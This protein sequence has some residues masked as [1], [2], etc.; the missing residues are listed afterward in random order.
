MLTN[1][2]KVEILNKLEDSAWEVLTS[3][4][5]STSYEY[6]VLMNIKLCREVRNLC[7]PYLVTYPE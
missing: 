3:K 7:F 2:E 5:I 1:L 4:V 6:R